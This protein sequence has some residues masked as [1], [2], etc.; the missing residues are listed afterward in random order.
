MAANGVDLADEYDARSVGLAL[1]EQVAHATRADAHEHLHEIG[2][3]HRE[4]GTASF[5]RDGASEERLTGSRRT[6]QQRTLRETPAELGELLRVFQELDDLLKLNLRLVRAGDVIKRHLGRVAGEQLRLGF[7]EA[8][9][10]RSAGLHRTEQEEPDTEDEQVR[11]K[12]D[13]DR[14][15]RGPSVFRLN[16]HA[17]I[18]ES[19]DLVARVLGWQQRP[20]LLHQP[21]LDR[22]FLLELARQQPASL[23]GDLVDVVLLE[24]LVVLRI[25]YLWRRVS[26]LPRELDDRDGHQYDKDPEREL[27]R[28]LAPVRRFLGVL[29]RH[30]NRHYCKLAMYGKWRKFSA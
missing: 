7:P 1:L 11:E 29:I 18:A 22:H 17:V 25:G 21:D 28:P 27:L 9:R 15:E 4:E 5:T 2:A 19:R 24:L 23:N 10:F 3:R 14:R 12:A 13:Q 6:H 8:E 30:L 16:L 20:E 26:S